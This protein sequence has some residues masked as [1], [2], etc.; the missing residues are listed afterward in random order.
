M[1]I[2]RGGVDRLVRRFLAGTVLMLLLLLCGRYVSRAAASITKNDYRDMICAGGQW[3]VEA[4]WSQAH[5]ADNARESGLWSDA[6]GSRQGTNDPDPAYR[7]YNA[8]KTFYEE[9]QYLAWYGN[10]ESGQQTPEES[11][12]LASGE[13]GM[14]YGPGTGTAGPAGAGV[15]GTGA[16]GADGAQGRDLAA[17]TGGMGA[18]GLQGANQSLEA[19]TGTLERPITGSTYVLEQLMD[20]DFL[21]KHF[22]SIHTSTTAGRDLMNAKDLLGRDM[23]MKGDDSKPQILIYH[24]H[25]QEAYKDSGPGQTVV[26]VGDYLTRLLEAKGY[27]VYHDKSVY[28]LKNGQLDR[29]KAYN[30]AL[31]GITGILQKNPSIEVVLD[32]HRDGVGENLHLVTQVDGRDTAQIMFFN[33][34]SQTPE[35]P[36]EYLQNPYREDNLAFSLQMQLGAAA[37]YPGFTRK[38]YLKGLRYNEHLRPKSSLIEVGAQTNTYQEALNAMEPLSELLDMVL[39]GNRKDSI[40][41]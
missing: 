11:G 10:E 3:M 20:Y 30:Y 19:I 16:S 35:G 25:S 40:I 24:T 21:I 7:K 18:A 28:D 37:Y 14:G 4:I 41:Q 13:A 9:H 23:T 8:V 36:I 29:S 22:Y 17:G 26:G 38:I 27:N 12:I 5:P 1:R 34:L 15:S 31:D 39:Q 33:G 2:R 6:W 32:I